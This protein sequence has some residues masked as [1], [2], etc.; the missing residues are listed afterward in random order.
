VTLSERDRRALL[1]LGVALAGY[2]VFWLATREEASGAIVAPAES[3]PML[4]ERLQRVREASARLPLLERQLVESQKALEAYEQVLLR[5]A[6]AQQA[7]AQMLEILRAL[8]AEQ[9]PPIEF[10]S[11]ELGAVRPLAEGLPYGEVLVGVSFECSVDQL[12]NFL[13]DV[14]AQPKAIA[15][16]QIRIPEAN[17]ETK[18]LRVRI[19]FAGLVPAELVKSQGQGR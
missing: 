13:A 19:Q 14:A 9:A 15:T 17:R 7:Q 18:Q 4:E 5:A 8:G 6:T 3:I 1:L 10:R 16:D 12:V 2:L 11:V